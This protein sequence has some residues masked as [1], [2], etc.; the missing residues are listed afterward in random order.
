MAQSS[1]KPRRHVILAFDTF[2]LDEARFELRRSGEPIPMQA[3]AFD[4][5]L[6]LVKNRH[7][8]VT[9]TELLSGLWRD[10]AVTN[11][12][13]HQAIFL[14]RR[15]LATGGA[16]REYVQTVRGRGFRFVAQVTIKAPEQ[17][18]SHELMKY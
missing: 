1:S 17:A 15:A 18:H 2:E 10:R 11:G 12:S 7:R 9:V 13:V 5:M 6:Y 16:T 4:A 14:V 8:V 3:R